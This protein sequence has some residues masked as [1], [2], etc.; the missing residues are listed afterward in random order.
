MD[1]EVAEYREQL[2]DAR[3]RHKLATVDYKRIDEFA[4]KLRRR[5]RGA[6]FG[7]HDPLLPDEEALYA[8]Q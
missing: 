8:N 5:Q 4:A 2:K 3:P 7:Q 1:N 6:R